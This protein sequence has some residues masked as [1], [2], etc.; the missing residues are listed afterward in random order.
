MDATPRVSCCRKHKFHPGGGGEVVHGEVNIWDTDD[1]VGPHARHQQYA[2]QA[3]D[4]QQ[5]DKQSDKHVDI[6]IAVA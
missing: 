4:T 2:F 3:T 6:V 5:T 1:V